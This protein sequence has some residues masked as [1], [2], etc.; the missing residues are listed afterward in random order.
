MFSFALMHM[1]WYT[2]TNLKGLDLE[3]V[4]TI[5]NWRVY[6]SL[7]TIYQQMSRAGRDGS[8]AHCVY[9]FQKGHDWSTAVPSLVSFAC[10]KECAHQLLAAS[11]AYPIEQQ[12]LC[13]DSCSHCNSLLKTRYLQCA[14]ELCLSTATWRRPLP[15]QLCLFTQKAKEAVTQKALDAATKCPPRR[16]FPFYLAAITSEEIR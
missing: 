4:Y 10:Q 12:V 15:S 2:T 9:L 5:I 3:N 1:A 14:C 11:F 16:T 8:V 6:T 13:G 7:E